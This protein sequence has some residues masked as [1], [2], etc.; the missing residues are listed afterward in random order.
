L[1]LGIYLAMKELWRSRGKFLLFSLVIALITFLVVFITALGEGLAASNKEYIEGLDAQLLVFRKNSDLNIQASSVNQSDLRAVKRVEGVEAAGLIGLSRVAIPLGEG[2]KAVD[3]TMVGVE[4]GEPGEPPV[5]RGQALSRRR[6]KEA[7]IDVNVARLT[8]LDV[9]DGFWIRSVQASEEKFYELTV[10]GITRSQKVLF[11]PAIFVP[12]VY[13]EKIKPQARLGADEAELV[14]NVVAV[15][16][17]DPA[18][19]PQV[20]SQIMGEV[21]NVDVADIVTA[22]KATP[23]FQ[24]Q[25][26]TLGTQRTFLLLIGVLVIGGFFQIQTLQ[27]VGQLGMLKA[28]GS[29]NTTVAAAVLAQIVVVT[30]IGALLGS[31]ASAGLSLLFP[32]TIPIVFEPQVVLSVLVYLMVIGPLGGLVSV[33]YALRV[34]PLTALGLAGG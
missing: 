27:K 33:R 19:W 30:L 23:G 28:I 32:P 6:G 13:W 9:G 5:L 24:A 8:G 25:Q 21:S 22:Y 4:P 18:S 11:N 14:S 15:R 20:M 16:L 1:F 10:V 34:E 29:S 7:I 12:I 26:S 2:K 17:N 3:V 31:G